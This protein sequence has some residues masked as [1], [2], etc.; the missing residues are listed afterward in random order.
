M[1]LAV[2]QRDLDVDHREAGDHAS[3]EHALDA[4]LDA[5]DV[6]LRNRT[7][8]DLGLEHVATTRLVRLDHEAHGRE[9]AGTAGL[10]LV[11]VVHIGRLGDALTERHLRRA[12]I[13]IDLVGALQD[14]DLDVEMEL[15]H[16]LEDGLARLVI[17]R[18]AEG[19]ILGGELRQRDAQLLLVGLRLRLDRDLDDRLGEFHLFQDHLVVRIAQRVTGAGF[20]EAGESDDV[21][22]IG[23]LDVLAVVRMH[24]Q[25]AADALLLLAGR[26][27][28]AGAR[29]QDA[30]IDAAE[31]DG[32]DERIVHDLER[33]QRQRLLV[34]RL[35]HDLVALVVGAL[36]RG[37]VER[38]RQIID[39][40][41]EQ[42]LHALVLEGGAAQHRIERAGQHGLADKPLQRRLVRF[43]AFEIGRHGVVVELDGGFHQLL[44]IFLGLVG[45]L[46]RNLDMVEL[47]AER[48]VVPDDRLHRDEVDTALE[49]VLRA[50]RQLDG[51]RLRA[52]AVDD[53]GQALEEV[54]TGLVHLVGEDDAR[55]LVLVTLTPDR[56]GLR[57]DALVGV[58]HA[59]GAVEHA[60]RP[61]DFDREVDVAGSVDDVQA[62]AVPERGGGSGGDRDA[63]LLLLLHPVH[64][65]GT[66]VHFADLVALAG[67]IQDALGRRGLTGVDMRHDAEVTIVFDGVL[68]G[69]GSVP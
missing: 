69:H 26:V 35:A 42:G 36:D 54:G 34:V 24:Q 22:R 1:I 61:L 25:H 53:V 45:E 6:F 49:V 51:N 7:A 40:G 52:Q 57:L 47:R 43:G 48:L 44:A 21:A 18:H 64:R 19:R 66:F 14:V 37:H 2:D 28:D 4:L 23:F 20:L 56:L 58:E 68:A 50:D 39:D 65:R 8:D 31:G 11:G 10:L 5:G 62:L 16:A 41:V 27:H 33:E 59:H 67:V 32:A 63:T 15:A 60:Q 12:D 46:S 9:L 55:H 13:R 38:R 29:G 30:R 17:G 3:A